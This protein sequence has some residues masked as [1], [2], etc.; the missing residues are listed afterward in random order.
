MYNKK[1]VAITGKIGSGKSEV[2]KYLKQQGYVVFNCDEI[3]RSMF[4]VQDV[5]NEIVSLLGQESYCN[6]D[7]NVQYV[8]EKVFA[9]EDLLQSYN[10][11]FHPRVKVQ[12]EYLLSSSSEKIVFVEIPL[13]S[14]FEFDW[15]Q[16]WVVETDFENVAK[17]TQ[18][19][20]NP[21]LETI[22]NKQDSYQGISICNNGSI[23]DLQN[24]IAKLL[25]ELK[26]S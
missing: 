15:T 21:Q 4:F 11:I 13:L 16:I 3:A 18:K 19:R 9:N 17:R 6:E 2:A 7:L 24:Q 23:A 5:K 26:Q 10:K 1:V 25:I 8:R 12:L 20:N 22:F 14:A